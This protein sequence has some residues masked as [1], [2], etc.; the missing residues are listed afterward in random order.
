[1]VQIKEKVEHFPLNTNWYLLNKEKSIEISVEVPGSVFEALLDNDLIEDPFYGLKEHEV[2]WV[3]ESDWDYEM[4]FDLEPSFLE[5]KHILLRFYGLDTISEVIL[6]GAILGITDNMFTRYDF[7]VKEKLKSKGNRITVKFKSPVKKAQEEKEK[8]G[9]NLNTGEAA[10]PGIPYLRKAQYS[11]GWDWGPKLPDIGIWQPVEL[12]GYDSLKI[13]S[14]YIIQKL[15]YNKNVD[16]ITDLG[17]ITDLGVM[18]ADL[19]FKLI[20]ESNISLSELDQYKLVVELK[21]PDGKILTSEISIDSLTPKVDFSIEYPYLWW[22]H[23]LGTPNLY[24]LTIV[25]NNHDILDVFKQKIGI[26]EICLIQ[27]TD[28]WGESYF[29]RLNGVPIF[30]KGANWIPI[31]SFIPRG[32]RRSLY[33]SNLFNAKMANMNM[34]RVWGGGVYEDNIFYDLCDELGILV[35]QDFPFAC[36]LYPYDEEF[37]QNIRKEAIQNIK[38]LRNHPSLALW[39]GNNEV[40]WLW[41]YQLIRSEITDL[42]ITNEFIIGY[43]K[44]FEN[45]LP[46]LLEKYDPNHQYWP[47][48]PSNGFVGKTFGKHDSNLPNTG[49]SHFW[50]VWHRN[51]PFKAYREFDSRFMSEFGYESLPSVKTIE[52][53]CPIEQFDFF[54]PIM[55]NHK[56][57]T[58]GNRKLKKYMKKRFIIPQEFENQVVLSQITQAEA[59]EYGVEHWRRNRNDYHC[60]G[61]L[62]WQ[63]ND[64]W[65][66]ASWSSL[67]YYNRWKA[68]HYYA[69]RFYH[70]VF[71]SVKEDSKSVEFWVTNDLRTSQKIHFEWK[72]YKSEGKV[73]KSGSYDSE[74]L[75]CCSK[76]LGMTEISDLNQSNKN[77]S[78]YIIFFDLRYQN[79]EYKQEIH[80]F[81]LFSAP[82]DFHLSDPNISWE[83]SEFRC[84]DTNEKEYKLNI[85]ANEIALYVHVDSKKFDFLAS[86]NYFSLEPGETRT[87][88][89][90]NLSLVYSSQ[91]AYKTVKK[92]DFS[93]KSLY[94]LLENS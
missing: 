29:F 52:E 8:R 54:S 59:I 31:D 21:A 16:G 76:K 71:P 2:S 90:K 5:H 82:K 62:Y 28:E 69:K 70:P 86:D 67:D 7:Q 92:E 39:C 41:K 11:F 80:G 9:I 88:S 42:D 14:V 24:E 26:R 37:M 19:S 72:I 57:N 89:L 50:D 15:H 6:N 1:M 4:G 79:F 61:A 22:T 77:L 49:D 13:D 65:P 66:V 83:L 55:E 87:I 25:I 78:Q 53:F 84:E 18:S 43:L 45:L 20:L 81:R 60:M 73:E 32:K 33:Q 36:A 3:Y 93:V 64:C 46:K 23:D 17:E 34:L 56:K 12:I 68:L 91:P 74:I 40:E 48:S 75:P 30:A 94:D 27:N 85:T 51:K 47:S 44:I 35:W 10:I 38:R 63:L 58:A